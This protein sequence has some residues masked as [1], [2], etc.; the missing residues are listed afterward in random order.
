MSRL[1]T[2]LPTLALGAALSA[3]CLTPALA[4]T[5]GVW[6]DN[7]SVAITPGTLC[8][9]TW[10][11]NP[12]LVIGVGPGLEVSLEKIGAE[13]VSAVATA[14]GANGSITKVSVNFDAPLV[15]DGIYEGKATTLILDAY[16]MELELTLPVAPVAGQLI[17]LDLKPMSVPGIAAAMQS[18]DRVVVYSEGWSMAADLLLWTGTSTNLLSPATVINL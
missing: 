16:T 18:G 12:N 17:I 7:P 4:D 13:A 3:L 2:I 9:G 10:G 5:G 14:C 8:A 1:T 6:G 11:D 15:I